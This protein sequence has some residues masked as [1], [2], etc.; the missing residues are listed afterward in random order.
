MKDISEMKK[1]QAIQV[2]LD[3]AREVFAEVGFAGARVDEIARR[4]GV[5]K[6]MIYYRI[7]NKAALY[8]EVLHRGFSGIVESLSMNIEDA[9]SPVEMLRAYIRTFV[10]TFGGN[11]YLPAIMMWE[12]ASGGSHMPEIVIIELGR[13]LRVLMGILDE[14]SRQGVFVETKPSIL[15]LMII[16]PMFMRKRMELIASRRKEHTKLL[17]QF[18]RDQS[19]DMG[20]EI[21]ELVMRAI[22]R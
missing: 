18:D 7:G 4:A 15:H 13:I 17:L 9:Q 3:A 16:G 14:G 10:K 2:I 8:S 20:R 21:E 1:E 12:M 5:N 6:A 22:K 11:P 19:V